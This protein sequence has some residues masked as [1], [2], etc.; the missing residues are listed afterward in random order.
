MRAEA[1]AP[2]PWRHPVFHEMRHK[3][4]ELEE[5]NRQLREALVPTPCLPRAWRL[6]PAQTRMVVA[7]AQ[8]AGVLSRLRLGYAVGCFDRDPSDKTLAVHIARART[9]LRPFGI[10]IRAIKGVGLIISPEGRVIVLQALDAV[11]SG[12]L[13]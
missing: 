12:S 3:I 2:A 6:T 13:P 8:A 9:K 4:E 1:H 10:E 5:E 7:L 11:A